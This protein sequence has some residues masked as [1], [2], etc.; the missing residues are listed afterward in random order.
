MATGIMPAR[1]ATACCRASGDPVCVLPF[2][3]LTTNGI[4]PPFHLFQKD[5]LSVMMK[6]PHILPISTLLLSLC[7]VAAA[8]SGQAT[9]PPAF[10]PTARSTSTPQSTPTPL[11][12]PT[13]GPLQVESLHSLCVSTVQS[14]ADGLPDA[15]HALLQVIGYQVMIPGEACDASLDLQITGTPL[16]ASYQVNNSSTYRT[17]FT[18]AKFSGGIVLRAANAIPLTHTVSAQQL[19]PSYIQD[20]CPVEAKAPYQQVW[21]TALVRGLKDVLGD[22]AIIGALQVPALQE[23]KDIIDPAPYSDTLI[24]G[25]INLLDAPDPSTRWHAA[26]RIGLLRPIPDAAIIALGSHLAREQDDTVRQNLWG[27]IQ[28][29]GAQAA[30]IL[31]QITAGLASASATDR[32]QAADTIGYIG[33]AAASAASSL[34]QALQDPNAPTRMYAARSLGRIMA[35]PDLA[36]PPLILA[37]RDSDAN[38]KQAAGLSLSQITNHPEMERASAATWEQWWA[39][40]PTPTVVVTPLPEAVLQLEAPAAFAETWKTWNGRYVVYVHRSRN[41]Q[42]FSD[43]N[44]MYL[45]IA[46]AGSNFSAGD[47][48]GMLADANQLAVNSGITMQVIQNQ[49]QDNFGHFLSNSPDY[50]YDIY[51]LYFLGRPDFVAFLLPE[52]AR[53]YHF[54]TNT[55]LIR[56][57]FKAPA[58]K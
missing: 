36:V 39:T 12:S 43:M 31:P 13:P 6:T 45:M 8:C 5:L 50:M 10:T 47:I 48:P 27:A 34:V 35:P 17:C 4:N 26:Q 20:T 56:V 18:G 24:Q 58:G 9:P 14:N 22:R 7:F 37:L 52:V 21:P 33:P 53:Y 30:V 29:G 32:S 28:N 49:G 54:D 55:D 25:L 15:L 3:L 41:I 16:S 57:E 19:P 44:G 11:E 2:N 1:C 23:A 40:P 51:S 38:V 46:L 42:Q